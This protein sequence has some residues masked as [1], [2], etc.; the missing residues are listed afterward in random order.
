MDIGI[1]RCVLVATLS[2][3]L[4][5]T[6]LVGVGATTAA[7][8]ATTAASAA[9]S[10]AVA[11]PAQRA[12]RSVLCVNKK[13]KNLKVRKKKCR[14]GERRYRGATGATGANGATGPTGPAAG[15]GFTYKL[16]DVGPSGGFIFFVDYNDQ[17]P[18]FKYL[19]A[20]PADL[21]NA[22]WYSDTTSAVPGLNA[23]AANAVGQGQANT[24]AMLALP[25]T[26]GAGFAADAYAVGA[27]DWF[28]PSS[29]EMMLMYTNLRQAGVGGFDPVDYYWSSGQF[30]GSNA[31]SQRFDDGMQDASPKGDE[32]PVLS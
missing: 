26:S 31:W 19:E 18:A 32:M 16:G 22:A 11:A 6:A 27:T 14:K 4:V 10:G 3:V 21:A 9:S 12:S 15:S 30:S 28:L 8:A 1:S 7:V 29:G 17:F 2:G 13:T 24:N 25:C 23:W 5:S 20:A